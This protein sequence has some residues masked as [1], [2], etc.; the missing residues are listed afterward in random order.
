MINSIKIGKTL[1]YS[2]F[3]KIKTYRVIDFSF[4]VISKVH[5]NFH[6][7][8]TNLHMPLKLDYKTTRITTS[9]SS[10]VLYFAFCSQTDKPTYKIF[11]E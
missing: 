6:I 3:I 9:I 11:I 5:F 4:L 8:H 10:E 2:L 7:K 1:Y